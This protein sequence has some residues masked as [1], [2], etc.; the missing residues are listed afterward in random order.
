MIDR[1]QIGIRIGALRRKAG[2]SQTALAERLGVSAQ[3]ISKWESGK[4]LPDIDLFRELAWLFNMTM[5][6]IVEG[7]LAFTQK[8]RERI[9]PANVTALAPE[10][11]KQ[12]LLLGLA[13]YC[14]DTEL[15][16]IA[17]ELADGNLELSLAAG[18]KR[19]E[20]KTERM[21]S[22]PTGALGE[23]TLREVAPYFSKALGEMM[24]NTEPGLRRIAG[25]MSCPVCR[26]RLL[27]KN[28]DENKRYF[29]C[30]NRHR[31]ELTDG[32]VH[33]GT[34]EIQGELWSLFLK[35]Y[36]DYLLQ[37]YYP[38]NP[39]Y[40]M[41]KVSSKEVRWQVLKKLRPH[42]ILDIAC[43]TCNGIKY[44]LQRIDWPCLVILTDLSHRVLKYGK[45]YF[46][47]E[48][49]N[50]YVD[51]VCLACDCAHL[52]IEDNSIDMVVSCGGF[53]SM[54]SK[55]M[56]GFREGYRVLKPGG[57]AVYDFSVVDDHN[58]EN[59]KK[60]ERLYRT[61]DETYHLH[62]QLYEIG[63]WKE[64]CRRT[65]YLSTEAKEIY[66]ELPA[67]EDEVFPFENEVLQWMGVSVFVSEK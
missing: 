30:K 65:G 2:M 39:R 62:E 11:E 49:V 48:L 12:K 55:M 47:E 59:T 64:V 23:C 7:D 14:S 44:D 22:I 51:I 35:N 25:M 28:K 56:D 17:K 41:G 66:R 24:G 43:G 13:P 34:R 31:Y 50:P 21:V 38:G 36:E 40:N 27:L 53:E 46:S 63:E 67:P 6:S 52:P 3:A 4:N 5:D 10:V 26:E 45:R 19:K 54:Q 58:S 33:F 15:Y 57:H 20:E 32:V 37:H 9:L 16:S 29:E 60:W 18:I 1:E 42:I 8:S 61:L